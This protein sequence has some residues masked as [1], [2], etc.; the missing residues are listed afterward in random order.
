M[1]KEN[2]IKIAEKT[3]NL[4]YIPIYMMFSV[5]IYRMIFTFKELFNSEQIYV[6]CLDMITRATDVIFVLFVAIVI[7]KINLQEIGIKKVN[8]KY[9]VISFPIVVIYA[10]IVAY[11]RGIHLDI[12]FLFDIH[13]IVFHGWPISY[14]YYVITPAIAEELLFRFFFIKVLQ[15]II[16]KYFC[17]ILQA[18]IF[19]L[20]HTGGLLNVQCAQQ[21]LLG[22]ILGYAYVRT[23]NLSYPVIF[24]TMLNYIALVATVR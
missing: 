21:I 20:L 8:I 6:F 9:V 24:H 15:N 5:F 10:V 19:G 14:L 12:V 2:S 3:I 16:P 13:R 7:K 1:K 18:M 22:L 23:N 4:Y 11:I 17:V